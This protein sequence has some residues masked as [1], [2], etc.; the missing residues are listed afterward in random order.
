MLLEDDFLE[1]H[2][3]SDQI[4]LTSIVNNLPKKETSVSILTACLNET[5]NIEIWLSEI[6]DLYETANL[7]LVKEIVIVDD[8][9][10]DGT[11]VKIESQMNSFPLPINLIRRNK[12]MGT[13]D[14]QIIGARECKSEYILIMD[15][16]L[17]HS[18]SLIPRL[19]KEIKESVDIV[20][21]SRYMK[22]GK[23]NWDAYRGLVSRIATF[24]AHIMIK[25]SRHISDPLSGYFIIRKRLLAPL[26]SY[27]SMY[28]PLLY[29]ISM[30]KSAKIVE[31]P[32]TM[33]ERLHGESKIVTNP[34]RVILKYCRE[35]LIFWVNSKKKV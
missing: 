12:K 21:G 23:N 1:G 22:G 2:G 9:S 31:I 10:T 30:S 7:K 5:D 32:I 34:L 35:I 8:G 13:L 11:L 19:L 16:D 26:A 6:K 25:N 20:V 3:I 29:A 17:Q 24:L 28:K 15:S 14:A 18:V 4:I 27:P 33:K